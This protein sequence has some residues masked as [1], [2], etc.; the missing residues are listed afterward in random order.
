MWIIFRDPQTVF[1][2]LD[3]FVYEVVGDDDVTEYQARM[4]DAI[5]GRT[6]QFL[7]DVYFLQPFFTSNQDIQYFIRKYA[8]WTPPTIQCKEPSHP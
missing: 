3:K 5:G 2:H 1:N 6:H 4:K 8:S 7:R